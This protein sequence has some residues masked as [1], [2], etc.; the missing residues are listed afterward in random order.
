MDFFQ[1]HIKSLVYET[2]VPSVKENVRISVTAKRIRGM[3]GIL[4]NV[5]NFMQRQYHAYQTNSVHRQNLKGIQTEYPGSKGVYTMTRGLFYDLELIGGRPF[6]S[7]IKNL[8]HQTFDKY[9]ILQAE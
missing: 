9:S 8:P 6:V 4:Q 1:V 3:P 7:W 5:R 2:P